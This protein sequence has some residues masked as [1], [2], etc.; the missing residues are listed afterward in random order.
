MSR[1][2]GGSTASVAIACR[3]IVV[4][5]F[6]PEP[7]PYRRAETPARLEH[8]RELRGR[9]SDV[10]KK[11]VSEPYRD[12]VECR[13]TEGQVVGAAHPGLKIGDPLCVRSSPRDVEHLSRKIGQNDM[14]PR[15]EPGDGQP[16]LTSARG[17]VEML[18]IIGDA[19]TLDNRCADRAQ[20]IHDDRV[21]LLPARRKPGPRRSLNVPD[22][23]AA[24][25]RPSRYRMHP[26]NEGTPWREYIMPDRPRPQ[27]V[28]PRSRQPLRTAG[29]A[30]GYLPAPRGL[31]GPGYGPTRAAVRISAHQRPWGERPHLPQWAKGEV[32][33]ADG[34]LC[35]FGMLMCWWRASALGCRHA[36]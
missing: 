5:E 3:A 23:I 13:V 24:R 30:R 1:C 15:R 11:H 19:E 21:P 18:L 29:S 10:G 35:R 7:D 33:V 20:L 17:N 28:S 26:P 25:H 8:A 9:Y 4:H 14:S 27:Q 32:G 36:R 12:T 2:G 31:A 22:L 16:R 6:S 34:C